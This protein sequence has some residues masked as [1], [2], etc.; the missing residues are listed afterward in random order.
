[1]SKLM[2]MI[3][4]RLSLKLS[5]GITLSLAVMFILSIGVLFARS[6]QMVKQE[7]LERVEI[8]L[9]NMM[10]RVDGMMNE[11][12]NAARTAEWNLTDDKLHPDSLLDYALSIVAMNP[13]FDGCSISMEP[14]YFPEKGHYYSVYAYR[15]KYKGKDTLMSKVESPYD[16]F[17]KV[18]YK[19]PIQLGH[20]S[21]VEAYAEDDDGVTSA[22]YE[23]LIVSYCVPLHNSKKEI[24]GVIS[25][26]LSMPWLAKTIQEYKPYKSSYSTMLGADGQYLIHPD[27]TKLMHKTI[28]TDLDPQTQ[29]DLISLGHDMIAG[30]KG[31]MG[32]KV[33]GKRCIALYQSLKRAPWS[34]ALICQETDIMAGYTKLLYIL[35]PLLVFGLLV[36]LA[37]CLN[38]VN[39]VVRPIKSLTEKLSYITNGHF[40]E[41]IPTTERKDVI[42][43]L[44]NNFAEMQKALS[45]H[46][47]SL[48]DVNAAT[49]QMNKELEEASEQAR[50]A[51]EKKNEFLKDITH[52]IRTPLNIMNGFIQVLRDDYESIPKDEVNKIL[53]TMQTNAISISRMVN[54]LIVAANSDKNVKI[55]TMEEVNVRKAVD[56]I[57]YLCDTNPPFTISIITDVKVSDDLVVKSNWEVLTKALAEL[58]YNAKKYTTEGYV[59]LSAKAEGLTVVF[60][61]EDTGPG[62]DEETQKR[63][64][65]NFEK[66]DIFAEG[67][68]LGLPCCRQ[69]VRMLGGDLKY[70]T[71]YTNGSRFKLIIP[72]SDG[73]DFELQ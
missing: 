6:R 71:T 57:K 54:M 39:N 3:S 23:D 31:I 40:K 61:V 14:D 63:L 51:D 34:M 56:F 37:F 27:T 33:N 45:E 2:D 22:S 42:G 73:G 69:M 67:L 30:N 64:F 20:P 8:E 4:K 18:Y 53:D 24:V 11:V 49:K 21:W 68:G 50:K 28:F 70:D 60:E 38:V 72:N 1:M 10:K 44:Q 59:K 16:Y 58:A 17:D 29:Q 13:N 25:T 5:L 47:S 35:I 19:T 26:D 15:L 43:R 55:N 62:I 65:D 41:H 46:I 9:E 66:G 48:Q 32:V 52:Q 36:I 12:E 7:A